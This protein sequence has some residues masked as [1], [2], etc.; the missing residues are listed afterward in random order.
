M[1]VAQTVVG[2]EIGGIVGQGH[3]GADA[4]AQADGPVEV[5]VPIGAVAAAY[6]ADSAAVVV[7]AQE[8]FAEAGGGLELV[9]KTAVAYHEAELL[10][11][12]HGSDVGGGEVGSTPAGGTAV[13]GIVYPASPLV[14]VAAHGG[15]VGR[16]AA[17]DGYARG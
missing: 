5:L 17:A 6:V 8:R 4:A 1:R 11:V 16:G 13:S 12:G 3:G 15:R 10:G 7:L 9:G 2:T 14:I